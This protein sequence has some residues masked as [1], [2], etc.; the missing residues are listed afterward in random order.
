LKACVDTDELLPVLEANNWDN[1]TTKA[2]FNPPLL[3]GTLNIDM[4]FFTSDV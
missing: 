3:Y 2:G 4:Q 1:K